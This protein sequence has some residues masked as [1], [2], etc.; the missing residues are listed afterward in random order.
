[1]SAKRGADSGAG[2]EALRPTNQVAAE[3]LLLHG[4]SNRTRNQKLRE[5]FAKF[6]HVLHDRIAKY[7]QGFG[8]VINA[9]FEHAEKGIKGM[10]AKIF[11][12][13]AD[14]QKLPRGN[15][16]PQRVIR[17]LAHV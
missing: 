16:Q 14:D 4:L 2:N 11:A 5:A 8:F 12:G 13:C 1:M 15:Q 7:T 3:K 6:D 9:N 10:E 17:I